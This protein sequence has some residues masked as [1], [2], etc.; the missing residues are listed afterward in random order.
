MIYVKLI[1]WLIFISLFINSYTRYSGDNFITPIFREIFS[2]GGAVFVIFLISLY[3]KKLQEWLGRIKL[4]KLNEIKLEKI[5]NI[6][7][8]P[9]GWA[10]LIVVVVVVVFSFYWFSLRPAQIKKECYQRSLGQYGTNY[11]VCLR[12]NG[13]E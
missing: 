7:H 8:I 9:I 3:Y 2:W 4:I 12:Q 1:G 6:K 11:G 5:K 13:L 10:W